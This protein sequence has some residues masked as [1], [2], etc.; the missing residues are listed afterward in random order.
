[1]QAQ[2]QQ[3]QQQHFLPQQQQQLQQHAMQQ[4]Q[5]PLHVVDAAGTPALEGQLQ[6]QPQLAQV[7]E[8]AAH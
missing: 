5:Q 4:Q 1:M 6:Q 7:T 8:Q 3:Q 2:Q